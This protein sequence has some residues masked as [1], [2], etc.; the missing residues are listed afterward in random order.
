MLN[1][2]EGEAILKKAE[3]I[4]KQPGIYN[5]YERNCNHL[6]QEVLGE[7]SQNFSPVAGSSEIVKKR[8][9]MLLEA[10]KDL[11]LSKAKRILNETYSK[12]FEMGILPNGAYDKGVEFAKQRKYRYGLLP[13]RDLS[14]V[15]YKPAPYFEPIIDSMAQFQKSMDSRQEKFKI[16]QD[17]DQIYDRRD[18]HHK[19]LVN[20]HQ[21]MDKKNI[22]NVY[23]ILNK[24]YDLK[25]DRRGLKKLVDLYNLEAIRL[26]DIQCTLIFE[27]IKKN[28]M[29]LEGKMETKNALNANESQRLFMPKKIFED[30]RPFSK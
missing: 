28:R 4:Y 15:L 24:H 17:I 1:R 13:I 19:L 7:I 2:S 14:E 23:D 16:L 9:A 10:I 22:L 21:E 8:L 11:N 12:V 25:M 29:R 26:R 30:L 20:M 5:L 18:P 6:T 3:Q 27:Y